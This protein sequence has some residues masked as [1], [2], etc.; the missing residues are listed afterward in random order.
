MAACTE[1]AQ[2]VFPTT[3]PIF[4]LLCRFWKTTTKIGKDMHHHWPHNK[5]TFAQ[6]IFSKGMLLWKTST[7]CFSAFPIF[8]LLWCLY[9]KLK[10][11]KCFDW[12]ESL[13][14]KIDWIKTGSFV[15]WCKI[16]MGEVP[17]IWDGY[18]TPPKTNLSKTKV[19]FQPL[20]FRGH[21]SFRGSEQDDLPIEGSSIGSIH[22]KLYIES[23]CLVWS[24]KPN[25]KS[26]GQTEEN[27][28]YTY[29]ICAAPFCTGAIL[30][31]SRAC[32][33]V[34]LLLSRVCKTDEGRRSV[35]VWEELTPAYATTL[36]AYAGGSNKIA[37]AEAR[38]PANNKKES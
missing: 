8:C 11:L 32:K 1:T 22:L 28:N 35:Q 4:G 25:A 6:P 3:F 7:A 9:F 34:R 14:C 12:A 27:C 36:Q 17:A 31:F 15:P 23:T 30:L 21:V 33:T 18:N 20:F 37:Q 26:F 2:N 13:N 5:H 24:V 38:L 19:V 16:S 10:H 29:T